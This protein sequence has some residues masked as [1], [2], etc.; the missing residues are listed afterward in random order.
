MPEVDLTYALCL[1]HHILT[2]L[3][4]VSFVRQAPKLWRAWY[5]LFILVESQV[6]QISPRQLRGFLIFTVFLWSQLLLARLSEL[7][8]FSCT[9]MSECV[10]ALSG[11]RQIPLCCFYLHTTD[12]SA[13]MIPS[14]STVNVGGQI[15]N[16]TCFLPDFGGLFPFLIL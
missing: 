8:D 13:P 4:N 15:D 16:S 2:L 7:A 1:P 11:R 5:R 9:V 6:G 3:S 10:C 14:I 12:F